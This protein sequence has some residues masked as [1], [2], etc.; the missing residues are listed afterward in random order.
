MCTQCYSADNEDY[1]G[2][3]DTLEFGSGADPFNCIAA[4]DMAVCIPI[5]NDSIDD[6]R[7]NFSITLN[8]DDAEVEFLISQAETIIIDCKEGW[9]GKILLS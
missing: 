4:E 1:F 3:T 7:E 2:V 6:D 9:G 5:V 8:T